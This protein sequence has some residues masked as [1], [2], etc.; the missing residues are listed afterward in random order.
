RFSRDWSSDVCSS[1][2]FADRHLT[3]VTNDPALTTAERNVN[4]RTFP[5]HPCRKSLDLVDIHVG[6]VTNS[7]FC[8][9]ASKVVLHTKTF[10]HLDVSV[11][12]SNGDVN[13]YLAT[14]YSHDRIE[15]V[16]QPKELGR[17][18]E[19]FAHCFERILFIATLE[20]PHI[21]GHR[22]CHFYM[23]LQIS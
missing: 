16:F 17:P 6:S 8:G 7:A 21:I 2:L 15:V 18:V 14:R 9:T 5:G 12:H 4:D 11:I 13:L 10:E 1:D 20:S 23:I 22:I 3:R 19:S